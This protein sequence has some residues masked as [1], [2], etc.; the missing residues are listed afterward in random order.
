MRLFSRSLAAGL[1]LFMAAGLA[2]PAW[3]QM[4]EKAADGQPAAIAWRLLDYLGVDYGGAVADGGRIVSPSEYDEM[5][6][7]AQQ[8]LTGMGFATDLLDL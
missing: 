1:L 2:A 4:D 8:V 7:F 5:V 6:E 3:A